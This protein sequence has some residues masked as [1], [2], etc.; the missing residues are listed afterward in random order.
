MRSFL[1]ALLAVLTLGMISMGCNR[2]TA[3]PEPRDVTL[4][5]PGMF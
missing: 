3:P 4:V 1:Q 2:T 5:V